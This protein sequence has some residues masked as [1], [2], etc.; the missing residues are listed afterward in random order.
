MPDVKI[1]GII[2][3]AVVLD[4]ILKTIAIRPTIVKI[5]PVLANN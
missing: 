4:V 1:M 2:E 3:A 5:S